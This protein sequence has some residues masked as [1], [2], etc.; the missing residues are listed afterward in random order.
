[1]ND[2]TNDPIAMSHTKKGIFS[3]AKKYAD[4]KEF[5]PIKFKR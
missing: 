3:M 4:N 2:I 5:K 1:M